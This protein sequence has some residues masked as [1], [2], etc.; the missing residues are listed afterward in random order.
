MRNANPP[1]SRWPRKARRSLAHL[2]GSVAAV[3]AVSAVALGAGM[4][5]AVKAFMPMSAAT[6]T[7]VTIT[8]ADLTGATSV[9][10]GGVPAMHFA[11][12]SAT[13]ITAKVPTGAK[14][15]P[16]S[17]TTKAGTSSSM[18]IFTPKM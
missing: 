7:T 12:T 6:G 1:V 13:R 4:K 5:P 17:V 14:K 10:F 8:G 2:A 3:L 15:G 18:H 11:V 9:K 16:I